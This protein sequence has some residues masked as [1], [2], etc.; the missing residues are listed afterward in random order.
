MKKI[1]TTLVT[2]FVFT[3]VANIVNAQMHGVSVK[4]DVQFGDSH[5]DINTK[6]V[7]LKATGTSDDDYPAIR[8]AMPG[9]RVWT[10]GEIKEFIPKLALA[11][12]PKYYDVTPDKVQ[13]IR[14]S[15]GKKYISIRFLFTSKSEKKPGSLYNLKTIFRCSFDDNGNIINPKKENLEVYYTKI[16]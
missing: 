1:L 9:A 7:W 4:Q 2:V 10:I 8:V 6:R 15:F 12:N 11:I 16:E 13:I 14:T 5:E 3:M